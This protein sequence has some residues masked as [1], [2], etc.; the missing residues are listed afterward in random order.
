[1]RKLNLTIA[2]FTENVFNESTPTEVVYQELAKPIVDKVIDGFNGTVFAYG[3]TAS[4][5][6]YT[7]MGNSDI[8]GLAT[9]A[10]EDIF[11]TIA[12]ST[13]RDFVVKIGFIEIYNDKIYDLFDERKNIV[14][15]FEVNGAVTVNQREFIVANKDDLMK[16]FHVGN[17]C[18]KTA[19]TSNNEISSRSHTIFRITIDSWGS[20]SDSDRTTSHLYLV[21]LAGSE[22]PSVDKE[23]RFNEGLH[24]NKSLLALGKIIRA[25][26]KNRSNVTKASFRE[27][28]LTRIL[29]PAL[30][31]SCLAAVVCT[32][33]TNVLEETYRTICFAEDLRKVKTYQKIAK[34]TKNFFNS[35]RGS[36]RSLSSS[37]D[38]I[39]A[40]VADEIFQL[41]DEITKLE[42]EK[43]KLQTQVRDAMNLLSHRE[44]ML[45]KTETRLICSDKKLKR[46]MT[47]NEEAEKV[48]KECDEKLKAKNKEMKNLEQK[49]EGEVKEL[50][51]TLKLFQDAT[52]RNS[53]TIGKLGSEIKQMEKENSDLK[54]LYDDKLK[55]AHYE[56][57]K[58]MQEKN[59]Q[60]DELKNK[61]KEAETADTDHKR[62]EMKFY[63]DMEKVHRVQ[64]SDIEA[65]LRSR[66]DE[67]SLL[68]KQVATVDLQ[69]ID[70]IETL[71]KMLNDSVC[72]VAEKEMTIAKLQR[73]IKEFDNF[74]D[75]LNL[76]DAEIKKLT[77]KLHAAMSENEMIKREF[78]KTEELIKKIE[79]LELECEMRLRDSQNNYEKQLTTK[80][81][82]I[83][84]LRKC[85]RRKSAEMAKM[86]EKVQNSLNGEEIRVKFEEKLKRIEHHF[87]EI[88][89]E[90]NSE[91][92]KLEDDINFQ[93]PLSSKID[94]NE[95]INDIERLKTILQTVSVE[96]NWMKI[97]TQHNHHNA[98]RV[99]AEV[100]RFQAKLLGLG[101]KPHRSTYL[102][103]SDS[104]VSAHSHELSSSSSSG[105]AASSGQDSDEKQKMKGRLCPFCDSEF[106]RKLALERH[107]R[108]KHLSKSSEGI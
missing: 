14:N 63:I 85:V 40:K 41:R 26:G 66:N 83:I 34:K 75:N 58:L 82:E 4:G 59:E 27:C 70:K 24:I 102:D 96:M 29:V 1:M 23:T 80:S 39:P 25:M 22:K 15:I 11:K 45:A 87:I 107:I 93:P 71:N 18:K 81:L 35:M 31:G 17:A 78:S 3:Q 2:L 84:N 65:K 46:T 28:K 67:V 91:I 61:L 77:T 48:K 8:S 92:A 99:F 94:P 69:N 51:K 79:N 43:V 64:M 54:K 42:E 103:T 50:N 86:H 52:H 90:K 6:T 101:F 38:G 7:M 89:E 57:G 104:E 62:Q 100:K 97:S 37:M 105:S 21:D 32:V 68:R 9:L 73:K 76:K 20:L 72:E 12:E 106:T 30:S 60:M 74:K 13:D 19:E 16:H 55:E 108:H 47:M 95:I 33:A 5:K 49:Y 44:A 36:E 98:R 88:L 10:V 53:L 56:Y